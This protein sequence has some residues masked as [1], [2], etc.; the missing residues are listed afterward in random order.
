MSA[1]DLSHASVDSKTGD[2]P[3]A[4][5]R[6][7]SDEFSDQL[8]SD[9][10]ALVVGVYCDVV[11]VDPAVAFAH[12]VCPRVAHETGLALRPHDPALSARQQVRVTTALREV[13][14]A[15]RYTIQPRQRLLLE[16]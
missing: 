3:C 9:A 6:Q 8:A 2:V 15:A 14:A 11:D 16:G 7:P 13:S 1:K 5:L 4:R 10:V 12:R